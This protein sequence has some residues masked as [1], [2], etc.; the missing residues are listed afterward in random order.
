[1]IGNAQFWS[2]HSFLHSFPSIVVWNDL[3]WSWMPNFD[4][5]APFSS[6]HTKVACNNLEGLILALLHCFPI[7]NNNTHGFNSEWRLCCW[8]LCHKP[9]DFL[10]MT[11]TSGRSRISH[12][13]APTSDA[14]TFQWKCMRKWKNWILLG[15]GVPAAPPGSPNVDQSKM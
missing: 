12:W 2:F 14:G 11:L 3:K 13:G 10:V 1:M 5:S 15:G 4:C 7:F 9:Y 6:F 8:Q